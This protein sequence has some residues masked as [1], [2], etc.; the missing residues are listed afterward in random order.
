MIEATAGESICDYSEFDFKALWKGRDKVTTVESA[1]LRECLREADRRQIL[2]VGSGFGR[3]LGGLT[4]AAD[5]V[6]ALDFDVGSLGRLIPPSDGARVLRVA[7][8]LYHLPFADSTFTA[9]TLIRVHHHLERPARAFQELHRVLGTGGRLVVSYAPRPSAGTLVQ[10]VRH[11]LG[12]RGTSNKWTTFGRSDSSRAA[13][14]FPIYVPT[15][16]EFRSTSTV[17]GFATEREFVTGL[18]EFAILRRLPASWFVRIG[19][20]FGNVPA[21]PTRFALLSKS[22]A[23]M[24]DL[25]PPVDR[26]TCPRCRTP[27]P[28]WGANFEIRCSAC[29]FEGRR[30]GTVLDLRYTPP[31]TVRWGAGT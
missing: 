3:L 6:V 26:L 20:A 1:I 8:N 5:E 31:G 27:Q 7:A 11:S 4:R 17:A 15:L 29:G 25:P 2:E 30:H 22:G 12:A 9:A 13:V 16:E 21:F 23:A 10:D 19:I 24:A 18:E 14:P 28:S